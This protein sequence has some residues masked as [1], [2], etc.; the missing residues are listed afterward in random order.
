MSCQGELGSLPQISVPKARNEADMSENIA[1]PRK[2]KRYSYRGGVLVSWSLYDLAFS[3]GIHIFSD[4][5]KKFLCLYC[6]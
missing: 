3:C 2:E 6:G 4:F 5:T 1:G